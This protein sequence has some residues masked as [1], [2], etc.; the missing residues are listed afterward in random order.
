MIEE[1]EVSAEEVFIHQE[2]VSELNDFIGRR[3]R[4]GG[5]NDGIDLRCYSLCHRCLTTKKKVVCRLHEFC[6]QTIYCKIN[7]RKSTVDTNIL[8]KH[9]SNGVTA[10][11]RALLEQFIVIQ[12]E[13]NILIKCSIEVRQHLHRKFVIGPCPELVHI[14]SV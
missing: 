8:K 5:E 13:R 10:N 1:V 3:A 12:L 7:L 11:D 14:F 6:S 9:C 2:C 4:G